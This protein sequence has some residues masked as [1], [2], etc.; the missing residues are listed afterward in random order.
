M[1]YTVRVI[2]SYP[3]NALDAHDALSTVPYV[4]KFRFNTVLGDG[5]VEVLNDKN[6]V[7]LKAKMVPIEK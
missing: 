2:Y 3:V 4:V 1:N 5:K 6:E 7:V